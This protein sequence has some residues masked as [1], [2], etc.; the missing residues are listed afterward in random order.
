VG[1]RQR[2]KSTDLSVKPETDLGISQAQD[3][4]GKADLQIHH[5]SQLQA[6][7]VASD[8]WAVPDIPD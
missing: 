1:N 2:G 8:A 6:V 3:E 7:A 5:F 4:M